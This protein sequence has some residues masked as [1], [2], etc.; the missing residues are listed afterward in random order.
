MHCRNAESNGKNEKRKKRRKCKRA[1]MMILMHPF[2]S[3][4]FE[5]NLP[6]CASEVVLGTASYP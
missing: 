5:Y 4:Q 3:H 6:L 2:R 1:G